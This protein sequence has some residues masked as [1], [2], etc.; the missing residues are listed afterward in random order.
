MTELAKAITTTDLEGSSAAQGRFEKSIHTVMNA[1]RYITGLS[2]HERRRYGRADMPSVRCANALRVIAQSP[3]H[4]CC[5]DAQL[6]LELLTEPRRAEV[7]VEHMALKLH[8]MLPTLGLPMAQCEYPDPKT[9]NAILQ[10]LALLVQDYN[11]PISKEIFLDGAVSMMKIWTLAD[12]VQK[13]EDIKMLSSLE[14]V[15]GMPQRPAGDP[16]RLTMA[17]FS[18]AARDP[19]VQ[20]G[21]Y[22]QEQ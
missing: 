20:M 3:D 15:M 14:S 16:K 13:P 7:N 2:D 10:H 12:H 18:D 6:L 8:S 1:Q 11:S 5:K 19:L 4:R 22:R 9:F 21:V 17:F